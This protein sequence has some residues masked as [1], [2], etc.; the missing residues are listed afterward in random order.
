MRRAQ[1]RSVFLDKRLKDAVDVCAIGGAVVLNN[2][3]RTVWSDGGDQRNAKHERK[4]RKAEDP[5]SHR[6]DLHSSCSQQ[7]IP[8]DE[9]EWKIWD[10]R[11]RTASGSEGMR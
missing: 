2:H 7:L 6:R 3:R 5:Q 1:G 9:P 4:K 8:L 10:S 11:T